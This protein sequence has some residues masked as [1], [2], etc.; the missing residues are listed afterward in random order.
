MPAFNRGCLI[1]CCT[2]CVLRTGSIVED[3]S[4]S[5]N[6]L[7]CAPTCTL[8]QFNERIASQNNMRRASCVRLATVMWEQYC[9]V[10]RSPRG[11][12]CV[13]VHLLINVMYIYTVRTCTVTA[14]QVCTLSLPPT[15]PAQ[16]L[17]MVALIDTPMK[18]SSSS[19]LL[20]SI[21]S[22]GPANTPLA[23]DVTEPP[24]ITSQPP[25]VTDKNMSL[26]HK[27]LY[28]CTRLYCIIRACTNT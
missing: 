13:H 12:V 20:P 21:S 6:A 26:P 25:E 10:I 17:I 28:Y 3:T 19:P 16:L 27:A 24:A 15:L 14:A 4:G 22:M 9:G 5:S 1:G 18:A 23:H 7:R 2:S 8:K 11:P